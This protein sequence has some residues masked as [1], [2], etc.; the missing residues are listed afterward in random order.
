MAKKRSTK[1]T[2]SRTTYWAMQAMLRQDHVVDAAHARLIEILGVDM[3]YPFFHSGKPV[4][5]E[6]GT[7]LCCF[8]DDCKAGHLFLNLLEVPAW[9][10]SDYEASCRSLESPSKSA[11]MGVDRAWLTIKEEL[12]AGRL[13]HSGL[14][15]PPVVPRRPI[16]ETKYVPLFI[17]PMSLSQMMYELATEEVVAHLPFDLGHLGWSPRL[18]ILKRFTDTEPSSP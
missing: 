10:S 4:A 6:D 9:A 8:I 13:Y 12:D 2:L 14:L 17:G 18:A 3:L 11:Y 7:A 5:R 16:P 15:A 1:N